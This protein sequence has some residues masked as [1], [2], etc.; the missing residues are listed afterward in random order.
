FKI[1]SVPPDKRFHE[2][3]EEADPHADDVGAAAAAQGQGFLA[4]IVGIAA[5]VLRRF[6]VNDHENLFTAAGAI[7][8]IG[9]MVLIYK[10]MKEKTC[11]G[12]N[13]LDVDISTHITISD[14]SAE[15]R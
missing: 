5:L 14:D 11:A 10:L 7:H 9:I 15:R 8:S 2:A 3:A 12:T 13:F 4:I 6:I 1:S